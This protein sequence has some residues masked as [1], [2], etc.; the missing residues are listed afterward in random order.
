MRLE[1]YDASLAWYELR[2]YYVK[3]N[4]LAIFAFGKEF[5]IAL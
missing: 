4:W 5:K 2:C 1:I 3:H